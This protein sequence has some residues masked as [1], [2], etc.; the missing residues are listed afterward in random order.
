MLQVQQYSRVSDPKILR[1]W[2]YSQYMIL[3]CCE[4]QQ[5]PAVHKAQILRAHEVPE[6]FLSK[7]LYIY[8]YSQLLGA[9]VQYFPLNI[10]FFRL[11]APVSRLLP[12]FKYINTLTRLLYS[13]PSNTM[14]RSL[15]WSPVE[16]VLSNAMC[17]TPDQRYGY[18]TT[19]S[20]CQ[21][22]WTR[23]LPTRDSSSITGLVLDKSFPQSLYYHGVILKRPREL[24]FLVL[25]ESYYARDGA[26]LNGIGLQL[27]RGVRLCF[28]H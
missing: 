1:V 17:V 23:G 7:I 16:G 19:C 14:F 24:Y 10:S 9:S 18:Y 26:C 15:W 25:G 4:Y 28:A 21:T 13:G 6:V 27:S 2:E 11:R 3:K 20:L 22:I 5:Y 8:T 12:F